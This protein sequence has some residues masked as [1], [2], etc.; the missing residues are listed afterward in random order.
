MRNALKLA[1]KDLQRSVRDRSAL[2]VSIV[3]PLLLAFILSAV[4]PDEELDITYGYLDQD[5]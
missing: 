4:L 1:R 2:A 3:A 5:G